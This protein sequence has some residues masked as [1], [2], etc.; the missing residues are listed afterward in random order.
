MGL[1]GMGLS[2]LIPATVLLAISFFVLLALQNVKTEGLRRFGYVVLILLW[3]STFISVSIGVYAI[4][5]GHSRSRK[6]QK[7]AVPEDTGGDSLRDQ[8]RRQMQKEM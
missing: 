8:M 3:L 5:A 6:Y 1:I 4:A 7:Q 2:G